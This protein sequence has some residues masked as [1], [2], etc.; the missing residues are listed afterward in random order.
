MTTEVKVN[1]C[2][3]SALKKQEGCNETKSNC[4][5]ILIDIKIECDERETKKG[6]VDLNTQRDTKVEL[7][8]AIAA[9]A[10]LSKAD[11]GRVLQASIE[12]LVK[13]RIFIATEPEP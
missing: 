3:S 10:K 4:I 5:T 12:A 2:N 9:S 1:I 7:I 11:A 8:D 6:E 13:Q